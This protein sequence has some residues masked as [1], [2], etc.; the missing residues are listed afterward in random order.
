MSSED[1]RRHA[2]T[3]RLLRWLSFLGDRDVTLDGISLTKTS[4]R[5]P[6]VITPSFYRR[7]GCP[8]SC[9]AVC[10]VATPGKMD[11]LLGESAWGMLPR[12][13]K[14]KFSEQMIQI[15]DRE[16]VFQ[17]VEKHTQGTKPDPDR[18]PESFCQFLGPVREG[19]AWGCTLHVYGLE[20]KPLCCHG[21]LEFSISEIDGRLI[22]M[23]Q[24]GIGRAWH[25][26]P[27]PQCT[28][29]EEARPVI[30]EKLAILVRLTE[31]ARILEIWP[32]HRR[33]VDII[34]ALEEVDRSGVLPYPNLT[35]D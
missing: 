21:F 18:P 4:G 33:I 27:S 5:L 26:D 24:R 12:S 13:V 8:S 14:G 17:R 35:F 7:F 29:E 32:A 11:Y 19:G 16:F 1:T 28:F 6:V 30:R 22:Q 23:G 10:C 9:R 25:Y 3:E 20:N 15:N 31:W 34:S 2:G